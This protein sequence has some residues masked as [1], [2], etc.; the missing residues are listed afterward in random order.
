[1]K[2]YRC[3]EATNEVVKLDMKYKGLWE[4]VEQFERLLS[5]GQTHGHQR[6][7]GLGLQRGG[8]PASI[9][10]SRVIHP[11]LG[12]KSSGLRYIYERMT[13]NGDEYAVALTVYVHQQSI[14]EADVVKRIQ[15]RC[16]SFE[17]TLDGIRVLERSPTEGLA[18]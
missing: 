11:Q 4:S 12:G 18:E 17:A 13:I 6:Y 2:L 1:M 7:P 10:K 16:R 15:Q 3:F 14:K 5:S 8:E 9:W